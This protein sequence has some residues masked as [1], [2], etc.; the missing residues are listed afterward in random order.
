MVISNACASNWRTCKLKD[1]Q[2][3]RLAYPKTWKLADPR[4]LFLLV[5]LQFL[6]L[7]PVHAQVYQ[8]PNFSFSSH[9]TLE[10]QSIEVNDSLTRVYM[11]ILSRKLGGTFCVDTN[12]YIR[13]SLGTEEYKLIESMGVPDCPEVHKFSI[14]GKKL[15]FILVFPAISKDLKYINII[16]ECPETCISIRYILLDNEINNRINQAFDLYEKRK[17]EESL[18]IFKDLMLSYNDNISPV[19]G[20][21]YLYMISI[22]YELGD[23]KEIHR[24]YDELQQSSIIN[25]EEILEEVR[26]QELIR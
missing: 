22:N 9:E 21:I 1:S 17:M 20:T 7:F 14:I 18:K 24:L 19:F 15:N 16:E 12:T 4:T 11:S 2:I 3:R 26:Y 23:S 25:R 10:L 8:R 6:L 5:L 13:N